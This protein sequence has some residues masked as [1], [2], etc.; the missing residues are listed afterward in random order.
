MIPMALLPPFRALPRAATRSKAI[1]HTIFGVICHVTSAI[2]DT[3]PPYEHI[4]HILL[5]SSH[6]ITAARG[7]GLV[8]RGTTAAVSCIRRKLCSNSAYCHTESR[9]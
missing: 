7:P 8:L 6:A 3:N 2:I 9:R 4:S 1:N 5:L